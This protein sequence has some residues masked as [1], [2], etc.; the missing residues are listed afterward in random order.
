MPFHT[1]PALNAPYCMAA[2]ST[3]VQGAR[4]WGFLFI[5][6]FLVTQQSALPALCCS[7]Q[8]LQLVQHAGV[9]LYLGRDTLLCFFKRSHGTLTAWVDLLLYFMADVSKLG[10][11][12]HC[13]SHPYPSN[14]MRSHSPTA[15]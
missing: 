14:G 3:F 4:A 8:H 13:L 10:E 12:G 11:F 1:P 9:C 7:F 6:C 2:F 15:I 5:C